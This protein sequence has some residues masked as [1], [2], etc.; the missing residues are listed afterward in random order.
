[1]YK[2]PDAIEYDKES[3]RILRDI[4][5]FDV[6]RS[7]KRI[8]SHGIEPRTNLLDRTFVQYYLSIPPSIRY[9]P[10]N[11]QCEK[12]LLRTAFSSNYFLNCSGEKLLPDSI[13]WRTKE[14][15][16]DGIS[17]KGHSLYKQFDIILE[18]QKQM[19]S[20][21]SNNINFEDLYAHLEPKTL[22][23]TYYRKWF[24]QS[25]PG[26]ANIVPYFWM[27]RFIENATDAS[28]RTLDIYNE[29]K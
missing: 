1:M 10:G 13:L 28:A 29:L 25:Y 6:L 7:D 2:A 27:P 8:Y 16:S 20:S 22:E 23:Q 14:A 19:F 17:S 12:F 15:F 24:E 26:I 5:L 18:K 11:K 21:N 3:R 9:H 4:N